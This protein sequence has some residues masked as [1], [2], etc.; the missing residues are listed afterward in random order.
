LGVHYGKGNGRVTPEM[1]KK[2]LVEN[3]RYFL[4]ISNIRDLLVRPGQFGETYSDWY[5]TH[6]LRE[7]LKHKI[8]AYTTGGESTS[9]C[10]SFNEIRNFNSLLSYTNGDE[11]YITL[12]SRLND[13]NKKPFWTRYLLKSAINSAISLFNTYIADKLDGQDVEFHYEVPA[14]LGTN[15][16]IINEI[17]TLLEELSTSCLI[18]DY[19]VKAFAEEGVDDF[20]SFIH[21]VFETAG[22]NNVESTRIAPDF[23]DKSTNYFVDL[24]RILNAYNRGVTPENVFY[25]LPN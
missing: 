20:E 19:A 2:L 24:K 1:I 8:I 17:I 4:D 16:A 21:Y 22:E 6:R 12:N 3:L 5:A 18:N 10:D 23:F 11:R 9:D 13:V 25:T 7:E 15:G 14:Y